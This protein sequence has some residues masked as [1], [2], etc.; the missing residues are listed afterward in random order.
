MSISAVADRVIDLTLTIQAPPERVFAAFTDQVLLESW[1]VRRAEVDPRPGGTFG[2]YWSKE[3]VFGRFTA[4]ESSSR[5]VIEFDERPVADGETVLALTFTP[6]GAGTH[7]H[8]LQSGFPEGPGW[9][10]LLE[11][12]REGWPHALADLTVLL[13]TGVP[14]EDGFRHV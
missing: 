10:E 12:M 9:D 6:A 7:L 8:F 3:H 11:G 4:V 1:F 5:I 13:E 14:V 2:C